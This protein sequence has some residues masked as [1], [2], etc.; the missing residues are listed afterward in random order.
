MGFDG[1]RVAFEHVYWDQASLLAQVG[2][3]KTDGLPITGSVQAQA[4][5]DPGVT[6]NR[7]IID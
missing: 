4:L 7:L 3:L 5:V 1:D 6:L 2:L